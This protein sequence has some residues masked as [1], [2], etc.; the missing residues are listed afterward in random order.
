[1]TIDGAFD[2][3]V[4]GF[5]VPEID[6][7]IEGAPVRQDQDDVLDLE[8]MSRTVTRPGDLW[9]L[10]KHRLFC[11]DA[12]NEDS[13]SVLA[14]G[15]Q[16]TAA[17]ID[18]PYNDPIDGYVSGFGKTHHREFVMASGEMSHT[19]YVEFLYK[20]FRLLSRNSQE[21]AIHFVCM[22]WRHLPEALVASGRVYSEFKNLCVWVKES[23]GQGS[24]YRSQHELI[25][26]F[27][28]GRGRHRNNIQLGQYG[29]FRTNV[30]KYARVKSSA[31]SVEEWL[32]RLHPTIKPMEM[33]ADAILDCTARNDIVLDPF[34]GSGTTVIAAEQTG[35]TC[36]GM[37]LDP[38][39][40]DTA[41]LRW[42]RHTGNR[43]ILV[44]TGKF[45]NDIAIASEVDCG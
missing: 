34:V 21:G 29:R 15:R 22:D 2:V 5:E 23:G 17:L 37:D 3:T 16:A 32:P 4:T 26:V 38:L 9:Q 42:Q 25:L 7:I 20:V 14:Q 31:R 24:F 11:G 40:I 39:Y 1:M 33:V 28:N 6:L 8:K 13:Y 27:K 44:A 35:R 30:W 12:L 41:V 36:H 19:E 45:F 10:G 43:A 18:P